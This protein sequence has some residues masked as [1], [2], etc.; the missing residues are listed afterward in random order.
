[1]KERDERF[2]VQ[3]ARKKEARKEIEGVEINEDADA[4]WKK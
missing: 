1:V 2:G 4:A 3:T